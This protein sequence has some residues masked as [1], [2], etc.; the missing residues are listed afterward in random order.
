MGSDSDPG[1]IEDARKT[2]EDLG[3]EYELGV[4]TADRIPNKVRI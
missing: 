3:I 1:S 2:L 4:A